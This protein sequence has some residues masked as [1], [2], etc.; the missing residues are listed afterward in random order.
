MEKTLS[1]TKKEIAKKTAIF[2]FFIGL[3]VLMPAFV[4]YQPIT[5]TIINATLFIA[6]LVFAPEIAILIGLLPSIIALS[7]GLLPTPLA[8]IVPF[9]MIS[10][11]I[12]VLT[13][14]FLKKKNLFVGIIV[15]SFL[16]FLFLFLT[17][18]IVINFLI[19]KELANQV[20]LMMSWP[21]LLTALSGGLIAYIFYKTT[22]KK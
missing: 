8:V 22:L 5:G 15:A 6:V 18:S 1:L 14:H 21:Q 13:F 17:S 2:S 16:K 20:A 3:V 12:L 11:T 9:I 10:N 7:G 4:H 19:K